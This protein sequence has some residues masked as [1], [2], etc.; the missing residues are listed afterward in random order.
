ATAKR[1]YHRPGRG[2]RQHA[3]FVVGH[4]HPFVL[5]AVF[6]GFGWGA[7][8]VVYGYLVVAALVVLVLP[9]YLRRPA[10]LT[11]A[12]VGVVVG[13]ALQVPA[14]LAWFVPLFYLKLLVAHLV[15]E[16]AVTFRARDSSAR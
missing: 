1:W 10:A 9:E 16:S 5:A 12:G 7:A 3:R 6:P 14:G 11:L 13:A 2:F 15:P 8:G 4:V